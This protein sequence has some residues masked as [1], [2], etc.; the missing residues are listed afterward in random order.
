MD[1]GVT[2]AEQAAETVGGGAGRNNFSDEEIEDVSTSQSRQESDGQETETEDVRS[3]GDSTLSV[4]FY[5][6]KYHLDA[7]EPRPGSDMRDL[8][9]V[10]VPLYDVRRLQ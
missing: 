2:K 5:S 10:R 4:D 7:I 1:N 3:Q 8:Q 9:K 6:G